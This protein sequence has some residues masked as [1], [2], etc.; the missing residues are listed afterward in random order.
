ME[1]TE[2]QSFLEQNNL[3]IVDRT[4]LENFTRDAI[5]QSTGKMQVWV[6]TAEACRL[7]DVSKPTLIK[8]LLHPK[9][10]IEVNKSDSRNGKKKYRLDTIRAERNRINSK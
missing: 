3:L 5:A 7:L 2:L 10:R 1:A 8:M 4:T 9:C 6:D